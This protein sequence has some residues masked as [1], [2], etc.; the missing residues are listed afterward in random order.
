MKHT[1]QTMVSPG[2]AEDLL[3]MYLIGYPVMSIKSQLIL[4]TKSIKKDALFPTSRK[5][6]VEQASREKE[7]RHQEENPE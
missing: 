2:R 7:A 6:R 1:F 5:P 3:G 4:P